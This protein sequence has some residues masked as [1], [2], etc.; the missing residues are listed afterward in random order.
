VRSEGAVVKDGDSVTYET[1]DGIGIIT[2]CDPATRNALT[3]DMGR[4]IRRICNEISE[5]LE[6]CSVVLRGANGTFCS[7]ANVNA[8]AESRSDPASESGY[9]ITSDIYSSFVCIM[10]LPVPTIAAV[11]GAAV[12]AGM[13]LALAADLR[14]VAD[15]AQLLAGFVKIGVHP[16]GGFF[17]L[18]NQLASRQTAAALGLFGQ[19]I[20]GSRAHEL[21]LA[22]ESRPDEEVE[23][24]AIEL[25]EAAAAVDV[26]LLMHAKNSLNLELGP[27]PI[28]LRAALEVERGRQMWSQRRLA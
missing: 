13:N 9:T 26:A 27:P 22:W 18:V 21:G 16:G 5:K 3:A 4:D 7:G 19:G 24:R 11:R 2:I 23:G 25:A 28:S 14:I 10:E 15:D 8:W 17:S 6:V 1:R 20:S 12:G